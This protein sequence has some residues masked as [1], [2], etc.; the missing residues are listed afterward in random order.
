VAQV[1]FSELVVSPSA[2]VRAPCVSAWSCGRWPW[3][4]H[5]GSWGSPLYAE[6]RLC[7]PRFW[8]PCAPRWGALVHPA[9]QFGDIA[10]S[11]CLYL[12]ATMFSG[13][14]SRVEGPEPGCERFPATWLQVCSNALQEYQSNLGG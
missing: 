1:L 13:S 7:L 14:C 10:R 12:W 9:V 2:L 8:G 5:A 3:D 4:S 6:L 11:W